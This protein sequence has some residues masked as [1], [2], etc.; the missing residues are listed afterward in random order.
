MIDI[1]VVCFGI[2]AIGRQ[3]AETLLSK[4]GIRIVGAIDI[5]PQKV[6]HDLGELLGRKKIGVVISDESS[7]VL[8]SKKPDIVVH[9]TT[10]YLKNTHK[11]LEEILTHGVNIVSTCE[12]LSYPYVTKEQRRLATRLDELA[13]KKKV[14]IL[15]TGINPGF[16]MDA[17]AIAL[18]GPCIK[19]NS[20]KV[21]RQMN[22]ATRRIPFQKKIGAG[23]AVEEFKRKIS[24][25]EITGHVGLEQSVGMIAGA[26]G[27][28]LDEIKIGPVQPVI[29][30]KSV[31]SD[32]IRVP[33]GYCAGLMQ[34]AYGMREGRELITL[35]FRAFIGADEDYDTIV[36][37]GMPSIHEKISPC[38]HGDYGTIGMTVNMIPKVVHASPG[39]KTM[40]DLPLPSALP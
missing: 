16:L 34:T 37:D 3:M 38:V 30:G 35:D 22:A 19:V 4:K 13:K 24:E 14:T 8:S 1:K 25:K 33:E 6:G 7:K 20:I 18:T 17:L 23:L 27:W 39:L 26:L 2:G 40:K 15:G 36:I 5:D 10:S 31:A 9:T 21:T 11:E 32:A 29:L 12:E 28:K